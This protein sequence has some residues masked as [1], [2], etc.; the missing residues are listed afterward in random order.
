[1]STLDSIYDECSKETN[2]LF[3]VK[4]HRSLKK[5]ALMDT[6]AGT[7]LMHQPTDSCDEVPPRLEPLH[8]E[9]STTVLCADSDIRVMPRK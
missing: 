5:V 7:S 3:W 4:E 9:C 1:V 2:G 8:Q 6:E